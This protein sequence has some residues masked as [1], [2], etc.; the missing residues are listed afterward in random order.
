VTGDTMTEQ[1]YATELNRLLELIP[2]EFRPIVTYNAY[3]KGHASGYDEVI[4]QV[5]MFIDDFSEPIQKFKDRIIK[6]N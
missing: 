2:E 5:A 3:D 4:Q 1:E 6:E